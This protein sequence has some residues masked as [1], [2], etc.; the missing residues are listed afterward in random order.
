MIQNPLPKVNQSQL[1]TF[2]CIKEIQHAEHNCFLKHTL[3]YIDMVQFL[4]LKINFCDFEA[5]ENL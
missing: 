4:D 1:I 2:L 3:V 5:D